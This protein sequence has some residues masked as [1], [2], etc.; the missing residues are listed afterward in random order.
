MSVRRTDL[1]IRTT[2]SLFVLFISLVAASKSFAVG[3]ELGLAAVDGGDDRA[4]PAALMRA[5]F[6]SS[7]YTQALLYGADFGPVTTRT[8]IIS[9]GVISP[10]K[11][12]DKVSVLAGISLMDE[13]LGVYRQKRIL[14]D[15]SASD[16]VNEHNFN[17]GGILGLRYEFFPKSPYRLSFGWESHLFIAGEAGIL[18]VFGVKQAWSLAAGVNL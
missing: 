14:P 7:F 15:G 3:L 11:G 2:L 16:P 17:F 6:G 1:R 8:G 5:Y 12:F 9:A 4:E 10:L 13:Y 18:L